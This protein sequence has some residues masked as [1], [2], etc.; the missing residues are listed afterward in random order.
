[1]DRRPNKDTELSLASPGPAKM[2][3]EKAHYYCGH[4]SIRETKAT[5]KHLGWKLTST[6]F[7]RCESCAIGKAKKSNLGD[8]GSNQPKRIGEHWGIDGMKLKQPIRETVHFP[9]ANCMNMAVD[10]TTGAAFLG[11]YRT[12]SAFIDSFCTKFHHWETSTNR[13]VSRIR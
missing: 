12:K 3:I 2:N 6:P 4:N 10:H 11:W 8:G 7:S 5:A 13:K 1:M 9:A